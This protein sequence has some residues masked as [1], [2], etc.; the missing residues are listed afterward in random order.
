MAWVDVAVNWVLVARTGQLWNGWKSEWK[1][2]KI[3]W[4]F[5]CFVIIIKAWTS[6][7]AEFKCEDKHQIKGVPCRQQSQTPKLHTLLIIWTTYSKGVLV[8]KW[9]IISYWG[10]QTSKSQNSLLFLS[11]QLSEPPGLS[12]LP[13]SKTE[14]SL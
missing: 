10:L 1:L 13:V 12:T 14:Y 5:Q 4:F 2:L 7:K 3:M 8:K 11:T 6:M 9:Q